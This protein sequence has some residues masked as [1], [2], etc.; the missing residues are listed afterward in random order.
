MSKKEIDKLEE[1]LKNEEIDEATYK[2]QLQSINESYSIEEDNFIYN[3]FLKILIFII[4]I[5]ILVIIILLMKNTIN[6][7]NN[8]IDENKSIKT[9]KGIISNIEGGKIEIRY[10]SQ[11]RVSGR[12]VGKKEYFSNGMQDR[13]S[14][15]D[16]GMVTG[17]LAD[18]NNYEKF[19]F[20][21]QDRTLY[22]YTLDGKFVQSIG[23]EDY[24]NK[25]I[26][27][28]HIIPSNNEITEVLK[29]VRIGDKILLEGYLVDVYATF[30]DGRTWFWDTSRT[31]ED[32]GNGACET[33]YVTK[34]Y[35]K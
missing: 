5:V 20:R 28:N 3:N 8:Q 30:D 21:L 14:P 31:R 24:I 16:I 18:G 11:Y 10:V 35:F 13:L 17:K 29:K 34:V 15:I 6:G 12:V 26:L 19:Q 32:T 4:F 9:D 23:G 2:R 33:F 27:N 7:N 25:H 1:M 22:T